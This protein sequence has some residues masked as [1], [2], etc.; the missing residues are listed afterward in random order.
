MGFDPAA[1]LTLFEQAVRLHLQGQ[2]I[3]A[4]ALYAQVIQAAPDHAAAHHNL[5]VALLD[6]GQYRAAVTSFDCAIALEASNAAMH[7][8]RGNALLALN[9]AR[10]AID[11]Y[12]H[13]LA[14]HPHDAQTL[15]NLGNAHSAVHQHGVAIDCYNRAIALQPNFAQAY[16][17]RGNAQ[18][19]TQLALDALESYDKTIALQP[20]HAQAFYNQGIVR[21]SLRQARAAIESYD[22]ALALQPRNASIH[23]SRGNALND[24]KLH[25][26]AID[27]YKRAIN[28]QPDYAYAHVQC[29]NAQ[30]ALQQYLAAVHSYTLALS[31]EPD[32]EFLQGSLLHAKM[33][34]C[35]WQEVEHQISQLST[36]IERGEKSSPTFPM[37]ALV[38]SLALQHKAAQIWVR[39]K[40]PPNATLG[41]LNSPLKSSKTR[42]GYYSTDYHQHATAYLMA[43]VFEAHDKTQFELIGFSWGP[44]TDDPMRQRLL[45]AFDQFIEVGT[46]S[47]AQVAQLSRD[48]GID[49]AID[50]KG[51]SHDARPGIFALRCAPIQINYLGYPATMGAVYMDYIIAD[52]TLIPE[53]D[54]VHYTEKII[55]LPHSYQA[56]D[57]QRRVADKEIFRLECGLPETGF[58]FCCFNNS[59]KI[60]PSVFQAWMR[61]L[62]RV[63]GSV[64]WLLQDNPLA[65]ENLRIS[66]RNAGIDPRR[67]VFAP[68]IAVDQHLARQLHADLCLD[69]APYNAHTTASDALWAGV[70]LL[71]CMGETFASRVAASLLFALDL[72]DLVTTH[73]DAYEACAISLATE[74]EKLVAL[75]QK[76]IKN[77]FDSP[78][79]NTILFTRHLEA[80]YT[81]VIDRQHAGLDPAHTCIKSLMLVQ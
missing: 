54:K 73:Q 62:A 71:T 48:M 75:R 72:P 35:Q 76:L 59:Y 20:D 65:V 33:Q 47:D 81:T 9:D 1:V 58:V 44:I 51:F 30:L 55:Y 2:L 79:F 66:A 45:S 56:N 16:Y 74:P 36:Q 26:A 67:L 6:N 80:A 14:L 43:G 27:C 78:L 5:G 38:D 8:N 61:I 52:K 25:S 31:H 22:H 39:H 60:T 50:L 42:I 40:H 64:L 32:Y 12:H 57:S 77:K 46:Q 4:Q 34:I 49:I 41:P 24:L 37:L 23:C 68:R 13:A 3:S 15:N 63:N 10:A 17:N 28:L 70:P 19:D 53:L 29:G 18:K 7:Y 11:S 69:T 21:R